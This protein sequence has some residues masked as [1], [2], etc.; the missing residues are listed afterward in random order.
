MVLKVFSVLRS[1]GSET[2]SYSICTIT[3]CL[4]KLSEA[5]PF[6][7]QVRLVSTSEQDQQFSFQTQRHHE[8]LI[9][10]KVVFFVVWEIYGQNETILKNKMICIKSNT[11][12]KIID[13]L[14]SFLANLQHFNFFLW[15][16]NW[17]GLI[18]NGKKICKCL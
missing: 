16:V 12:M 2:L 17:G 3:S 6:T 14:S 15:C 18:L 10:F 7:R 13:L 1:G 8:S 5:D 9:Y 11:K 4:W